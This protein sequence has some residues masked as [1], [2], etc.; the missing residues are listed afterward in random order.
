[1]IMKRILAFALLATAAYGTF[2]E[3][4]T[5]TADHVAVDNVTKA[6]VATGNVCA[7]S[8]PLTLRSEYLERTEDGLMIFHDPTYVTTCTN[9]LHHTHW[10]VTGEVECKTDSH[11]IVRNMWLHFYEVPV[12]YLPYFW[13]PLGTHCGFRFM[14]G[15]NGRWGGF[16]LTRY[17]YDIVGDKAHADNTWWM[18]GATNFD[19]RYKNGIAI[20]EDLNWNF[21]DFGAGMFRIYYA[22]DQ[23]ADDRYGS[24]KDCKYSNWGSSVDE[25]RYAM[26]LKHRWQATERDA[27]FL[28]GSLNSDSYVT[29]DFMRN[30]FFEL[31][32]QW[33]TFSN[34]G[35]F[36]E[37]LENSFAIGAETSGRLNKFYAMTERLP[38]FYLDLNPTS[39]FGSPLN[40]ETENRLGWLDRRYARY[41]RNF[42]NPYSMSPGPWASYDTFRVD[43]YHRLTAPFKT[44]GE[45][46]SI[47]PRVGFRATHWTD[48]G[49]TDLAG[50]DR[51][52]D[53]GAMTRSIGEVGATFAVRGTG[54]INESYAHT[55]EPY[56]DVLAQQAWYAGAKSGNRNR[57]YVFDNLDASLTWEDQY[58]GRSR[59]LPY[60]YYGLTPGLR[61]VWSALEENGNLRSIV[62]F[63]FYSAITFGEADHLGTGSHKLAKLGSANYGKNAINIMPGGRLKWTP[64]DDISLTSRAEFDVDHNRFAVADLAYRQ[65]LTKDFDYGVIYGMRDHRYWD[66]SSMPYD[67][68]YMDKDLNNDMR[69]QYVELNGR[70]QPLHW[71][72]FGPY[73]RWDL[74]EGEL[75]SVGSWFDYLTDCL[76]FRFF[77]KYDNEFRRIDGYKYSDD[78]SFGFSL[79]LRAFGFD[80]ANVFG[81]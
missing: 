43:T 63:D 36:W 53:V 60:S 13:Y 47:V 1:M 33:Q 49:R 73:I 54:W 81:R 58:A 46:L 24:R 28:R 10:N 5:F 23:Y 9:E 22:W 8:R 16:L 66:F 40:Y 20:G 4:I 41:S 75:D 2:A 42:A 11:I 45:T 76:G 72:A 14:L 19:L 57:P 70:Y 29:R 15:Y 18:K 56:V 27:I 64:A 69:Y 78:W 38:E 68:N 71:L 61:N 21:G 35:V 50:F 77:V 34:S 32:S 62:D 51:A 25:D 3:P 59:N 39:L 55:I 6:A 74:R 26:T 67:P 65:V 52:H 79:Y 12:F 17:S 7:V 30:N 48:S 44:A 31:K 37:H 80:S